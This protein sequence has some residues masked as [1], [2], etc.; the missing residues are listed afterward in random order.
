MG[1]ILE[2]APWNFATECISG[3]FHPTFVIHSAI[4]ITFLLDFFNFTPSQ[5]VFRSVLAILA[6]A[7]AIA[8]VHGVLCPREDVQQSSFPGIL[9]QN[10]FRVVSTRRL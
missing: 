7:A 9:P 6:A 2:L 8:S 10:A 3:G 5:F 4:C 1:S